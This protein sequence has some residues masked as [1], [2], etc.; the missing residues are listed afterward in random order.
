MRDKGKKTR[1]ARSIAEKVLLRIEAEGER[2]WRLADFEKLSF[3]AT[4]QA[5]SRLSRKGIIQRIGKGLYYRPRPTVFGQSTVSS[6]LIRALPISGRKV[7]PAGHAA[8]NLLGF[9]SQNPA[10]IEIATTGLSLPRQIVGKDTIIHTRRPEAWQKL[11]SR[12]AA[13]LDFIRNRG[14]TSELSSNGTVSKLLECFRESA[15]FDRLLKVAILEP[16][17]V[18]AIF[19][20]IGQQ[21]GRSEQQLRYLRK[22]LNPLSRFDFGNLSALKYAKQWQAKERNLH[23]AI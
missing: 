7:F 23:E 11:S 12:D 5:L 22:S 1:P 14:L 2:V 6:N 13:I 19:G 18:R 16:P 17:R 21:L 3:T 8:A 10:R 15:Q 9:S 20:A 4:A